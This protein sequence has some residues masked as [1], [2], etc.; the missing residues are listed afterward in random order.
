MNEDILKDLEKRGVLV[1]GFVTVDEQGKL[2]YIS[3]DD[4]GCVSFMT[5]KL[6][7]LVMYE[8]QATGGIVGVGKIGRRKNA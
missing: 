5:N 3:Y 7:N 6:D 2:Q 4:N 8:E 1:Q